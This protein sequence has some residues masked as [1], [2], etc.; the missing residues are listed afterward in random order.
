MFA[1]GN[2]H[3]KNIFL[4]LSTFSLGICAFNFGSGGGTSGRVMAFCLG[5]PGSNPQTDIG[6]YQ[7][8]IAVNL[9]SLG[10]LLFL[11][12]CNGTVHTIHTSFLFH[13]IIYH[14]IKLYTKFQHITIVSSNSSMKLLK[15]K[16]VTRSKKAWKLS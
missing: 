16:V 2:I 13:I 8:R 11:I 12:K 7:F 1:N 14:C 15:L 4:L 3:H 6:F 5:R 9:I 10:D